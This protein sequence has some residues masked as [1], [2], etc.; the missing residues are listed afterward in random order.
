MNCPKC[1]KVLSDGILGDVVYQKCNGCGGFWFD[2]G[3]LKQIKKE[4][5]WFKIDTVVEKAKPKI[6]RGKLKCPRC[7]ETLHTIEYSHPLRRIEAGETDIKVNVCSKCEGLWLDSGELQAIHKANE[8][9]IEK[10]REKIED[11]LIAVELF[12]IKV[13]RVLPG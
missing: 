9:W 10:L 6:T 2:K 4:K 1:K 8:T 11:D 7:V 5:D 3:D 12:L 13:G